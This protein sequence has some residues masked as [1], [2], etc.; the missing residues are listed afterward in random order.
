MSNAPAT[1]SNASSS[2]LQLS[3]LTVEYT[4]EDNVFRALDG[5]SLDVP[6]QGYTLGIVGESGSGKT[7]LGMSIMGMIQSPGKVVEGSIK[8]M[9]K[10]VLEM[11]GREMRNYR[12]PSVSMVYQSAMN[13]LNPVMNILNHVVEVIRDHSKNISKSEATERAKKLLTDVGIPEDRF[14]SYPHE[15]SGGMR[16]RVVIALALALNPKLLIADEPTSALDV[17]VQQQI[18]GL[19]KKHIVDRGLSLFF[20]THE[21][22]LTEGLVDN[23]VVMFAGEIVELG[24]SSK[25]LFSPF[26]PYSEE[27]L[28]SL[29]N[30]ESNLSTLDRPSAQNESLVPHDLTRA[31]K[32]SV[33]CKYAFDRCRKERPLLRQV[34]KDR[35]VACHKY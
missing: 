22:A 14:S 18:L 7:T 25:V 23:V 20:I 11:S 24:P 21:I 15:F 29:L 12:G 10:D 27:L 33:R 4:V 32:F 28:G 1:E 26:H 31:C 19:L 5:I 30:M 9:G 34:E 6:R 16:Q 13:S 35:W 3:D 17:I 8:F 2:F